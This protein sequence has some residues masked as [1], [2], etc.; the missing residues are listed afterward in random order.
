[1]GTLQTARYSSYKAVIKVT[2][3]R[4]FGFGHEEGV[5][6][7]GET[8]AYRTGEVCCGK[9]NQCIPNWGVVA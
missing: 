7:Q 8:A 9:E 1:M 6:R 3:P 5:L 2:E 4:I